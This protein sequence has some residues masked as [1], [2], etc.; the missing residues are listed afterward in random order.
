MNPNTTHQHKQQRGAN[1]YMLDE[2]D[3]SLHD[4]LCVVKRVLESG[5][6]VPGGGAVEAALS[7]Y[8]EGFAT[9][10]GGR[11]QLAIAEF[12]EVRARRW[13]EGRRLLFSFLLRWSG[14]GGAR[15]F[16]LALLVWGLFVCAVCVLMC[17]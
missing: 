3:R 9:T 12:A 6:V 1:D 11:E 17:C 10:L 14:G 4:S 13:A 16:V 7:A 8:L 15:R 2:M 5:A